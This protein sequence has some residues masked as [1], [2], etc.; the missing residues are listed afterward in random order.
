MTS[1][2][3]TELIHQAQRGDERAWRQVFDITYEELRSMARHR[4]RE[5]RRG[6]LLDTTSLVHESFLRF[7]HAGRLGIEDRRHFLRY[8]GRA[9]RSVVVDYARERQ[10]ARRGGGIP[11]LTLTTR[12]DAAADSA[13]EILRVHDALQELAVLDARL[14]QVVELRYFAGM[15]EAEIA[16]ALAVA[17]RTVRRDWE[18]ARLLLAKALQ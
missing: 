16:D 3:L 12:L 13:D 6:T 11:C 9:M 4:L 10:A 1:A 2:S 8:A 17:D 18:K 5:H 14:A 15:T 7:S